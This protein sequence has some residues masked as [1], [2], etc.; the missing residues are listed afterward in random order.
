M[1]EIFKLKIDSGELESI[2]KKLT[3]ISAAMK[4]ATGNVGGAVSAIGGGAIGGDLKGLGAAT[5]GFKNLNEAT[6][7]INSHFEILKSKL[8][9]LFGPGGI[10][11]KN[12]LKIGTAV[13]SVVKKIWLTATGAV[14]ALSS[15]AFG[16]AKGSNATIGEASLAK[17]SYTK[18]KAYK[19]ASEHSGISPDFVGLQ[20]RLIEGGVLDESL[21]K[22][23]IG[24]DRIKELRAMDGDDA[25]FS[26]FK[27]L[28]RKYDSM[29]ASGA[30]TSV[31]NSIFG[32]ALQN[33][34]GLG[35]AEFENMQKPL[36]EFQTMYSKLLKTWGGSGI[37]IAALQNGDRALTE[38]WN[39]LQAIAT[40]LAGEFLPTLTDGLNEMMKY[41]NG[42]VNS[43][44]FKQYT[45]Y[46]KSVFG[47]LL[48]IV[49]QI[50]AAL[51]PLFI[52]LMP[53]MQNLIKAIAHITK[54]EFNE[55]LK[56]FGGAG[57]GIVKGVGNIAGAATKPIENAATDKAKEAG[58]AIGDA[59][60]ESKIGKII[61][62]SDESI[63]ENRINAFNKKNEAEAN[64][65][66]KRFLE[67]LR[68]KDKSGDILDKESLQNAAKNYRLDLEIDKI[69]A[70]KTSGFFGFGAKETSQVELT[71]NINQGDG[72]VKKEKIIINAGD[73]KIIERNIINKGK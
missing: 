42:A 22:L 18:Q 13:V 9:E 32:D 38:F 25:Y 64:L 12:I 31:I 6:K 48:T 72:S 71:L 45:E 68:E 44:E 14:T 27:E 23:G 65:G 60:K 57:G 47:D 5:K 66:L 41:L 15:A 19:G 21:A 26:L 24:A 36:Q 69:E 34:L 56:A 43:K 70:A 67:Y 63:K 51:K 29:K 16:I 37:D 62:P 20:K 58:K 28:K 39:K 59:I 73:S 7:K 33:T 61:L 50:A 30:D 3:Q 4:V 17:L 49:K 55:A 1:D 35:V 46:L 8:N 2:A 10:L 40:K 53:I 11:A 52:E 54:G